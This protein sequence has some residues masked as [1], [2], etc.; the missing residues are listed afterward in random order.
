[1]NG[2]LI[3]IVLQNKH[4]RA[5]SEGGILLDCFCSGNSIDDMNKK[6]LVGLE[7]P[8]TMLGNLDVS[9]SYQRSDTS[10]YTTHVSSSP[11]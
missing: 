10:E 5:S 8:G 4:R 2:I 9:V 3:R 6:N 11:A 1:M 7:F